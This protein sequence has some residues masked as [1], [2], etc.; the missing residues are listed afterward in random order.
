MQKTVFHNAGVYWVLVA[1]LVSGLLLSGYA[2]A[3]GFAILIS[4]RLVWMA[5]LLFLV[6]TKHK[7]ALAN[8]KWWLIISCVAGPALSLA[9]RLLNEMLDG[10]SSF[11]AEFYLNRALLLVVGLILLS[12]IRST[13]TVEY[14]AAK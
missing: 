14:V 6:A 1:A 7:Y 4:V 10:F 11:S 9:G 3:T 13:V 2:L 8:L 5:A 12:Y